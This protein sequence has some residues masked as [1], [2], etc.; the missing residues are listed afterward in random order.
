[1]KDRVEDARVAVRNVRQK[2]MQDIDDLEEEGLSEDE[3]DRI[4]K[5]LEDLVKEYNEKIEN[6]REEKKEILMK[7]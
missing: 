7:I 1:M 6:M 5:M 2:Y 3:A 4:R